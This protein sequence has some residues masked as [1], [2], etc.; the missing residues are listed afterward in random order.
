WT[1]EQEVESVSATLAN[2]RYMDLALEDWGIAWMRLTNG[3]T[4]VMED[5]WTADSGTRFDRWIDTDGSLVPEGDAFVQYRKGKTER[6]DVPE[7]TRSP[8]AQIA[9][10][11]RG[12]ERLPMKPV[13]SVH[14]LAACLAVYESFRSGTH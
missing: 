10:A 7:Q 1:L 2:R 5:T 8:M 13:C 12:E 3:F 6:F 14:N 4:A 9:A 11:V